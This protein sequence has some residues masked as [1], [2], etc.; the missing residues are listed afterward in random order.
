MDHKVEIFEALVKMSNHIEDILDRAT[1]IQWVLCEN[2]VRLNRGEPIGKLNTLFG[3]SDLA[4][5]VNT[6]SRWE[7][8]LN[9]R[10][11]LGHE[12]EIAE[13]PATERNDK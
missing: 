10:I 3:V 6:A 12:A 2:R 9:D 5:M 13:C 7:G 4:A 8:R 1:T 11:E